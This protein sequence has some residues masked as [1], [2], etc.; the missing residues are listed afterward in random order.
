MI[1]SCFADYLKYS[2]EEHET[3]KELFKYREELKSSY[4]KMERSLLE[5][6]DKLF[7]TKDLQKWGGFK[8]SNEFQK[9]K[10]ELLKDKSKAFL[11]MLPKETQETDLKREELCF[12]TNQ[13]WEEVKRVGI[14][15]G[16]IL[17]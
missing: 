12:Y 14:E 5:K 6:K 2:K 1:E 3:F 11:F 10:D 16:K 15:N 8:D 13:C 9:L 7:K 17:R 4:I